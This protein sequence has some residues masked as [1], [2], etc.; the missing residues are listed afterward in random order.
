ML[1][2][3]LD[4]PVP[5]VA[6]SE[7]LVICRPCPPDLGFYH[8]CAF[9][10]LGKPRNRTIGAACWLAL[11]EHSTAETHLLPYKMETI[12]PPSLGP[13]ED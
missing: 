7:R 5:S 13:S 12:M 9:R 1:S 2:V 3:A 6:T 11:N 4:W 10:L 8:L